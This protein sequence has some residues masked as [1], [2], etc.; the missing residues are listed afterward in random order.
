MISA[1]ESGK[2]DPTH[3]TLRKLV[4]AA[5]EQLVV[6]A[7]L[8]G[9]DLPPPADVDEHARRLLDVLS[10]ADA[11][12]VRRRPGPL[13]R[14][15][16]GVDVS[17]LTLA[18]RVTAVHEALEDVPHAFG[19]ALAL[20]YYAEPWATIDIDV[21]LFVPSF[22]LGRGPAPLRG[23]GLRSTTPTSPRS[24][25]RRAGPRH[26]G[27]TPLDLFFAYDPFH[28]A[29]AKG[30][31]TVPFAD[32]SIPILSAEHLVVCKAVFNRS[33]DWVDIES[34]L[35]WARPRRRRRAPV[36]GSHRRRR[37]P[38]LRADRGPA[39]PLTVGAASTSAL[40]RSSVVRMPLRL[41]LPRA[42]PSSAQ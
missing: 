6:T 16:P 24:S 38:A 36:G 34:M 29:A 9:S 21:N 15:A 7:R 31:R 41:V 30:R 12:P 11:I 14:S 8:P 26:V 39:R 22:P 19:G 28:D 23:W 2:R 42:H 17:T 1:Y 4:A 35:S 32:G 40:M 37:R 25:A 18:G 5:G 13:R 10:L 20:A 33:K 27:A 3:T